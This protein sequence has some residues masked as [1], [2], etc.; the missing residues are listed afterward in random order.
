MKCLLLHLS[1]LLVPGKC[2]LAVDSGREV[3]HCPRDIILP[4]PFACG[5][6]QTHTGKALKIWLCIP[7]SFLSVSGKRI[8]FILASFTL[9]NDQIDRFLMEMETEP[10]ELKERVPD[11]YQRGVEMDVCPD[12]TE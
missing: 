11:H 8:Y 7:A 6:K 10:R 12:R 1:W 4:G 5:R 3:S 9:G 2:K